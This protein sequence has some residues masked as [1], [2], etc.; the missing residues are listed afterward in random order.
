MLENNY[1]YKINVFGEP[2]LS[3]RGLYPTLSS[4]S[5]DKMNKLMLNFISFCDGKNSL[6]DIAEKI[7]CPCW[8]LYEIVEKLKS[9]KLIIKEF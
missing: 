9:H 8:E 3:K 5:Q 1:I 7:N 2:Q 6:L 4:K